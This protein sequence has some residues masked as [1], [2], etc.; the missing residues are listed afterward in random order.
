MCMDTFGPLFSTFSLFGLSPLLEVLK[1]QLGSECGD[2]QFSYSADSLRLVL[3]PQAGSFF[4]PFQ[5]LNPFC[6]R[7][8]LRLS[9]FLE[10]LS[11]APST[12]VGVPD[13]HLES[14]ILAP[15]GFPCHLGDA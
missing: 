9:F 1:L 6:L 14:F 8:L 10:L 5:K 11:R 7:R 13:L 4:I 2:S 3:F 15:F 12:S